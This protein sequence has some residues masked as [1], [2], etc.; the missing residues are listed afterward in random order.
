MKILHVIPSIALVR[1]GPSQAVLAMVKALMYQGINAEIVTTNDNGNNLLDVSLGI[2]T[3]YKCV[4]VRFFARYSPKIHSVREFAFSGQL[5]HWLWHNVTNYDL[6]HVHAIFSYPSTA[7]MFIARLKDIPYICR[8]LGQLCHWSLQQGYQ[9]KRAYLGL[10]EK[11]N[12]NASKALH[13]TTKQE[14]KE[15]DNLNL[16]STSFIL[17]HGISIP[18]PIPEARI[19]LRNKLQVADNET[20]ILFLARL[21]PKKGLDYLISALGKLTHK[22][23]IFVLAGNGDPGYEIEV[24]NLLHQH[25]ISACTHRVGFVQ[26]EYKNLLLQGA[27]IFALTSHSENFGVAVIEALAAGIPALITPG[28]ALASILEQEQIGYVTNLNSD[29]IASSFE[30]CL[31][32]LPELKEKGDRAKK[33]ILENYTW[34]SI[35]LKLV[36]TYQGVINS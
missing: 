9:K 35:A 13:F 16:K 15:A 32:N 6:I 31:N 27:D 36:D 23:F 21:H 7:A 30:Y 18:V 3:E 14:Q 29:A 25:N 24:E 1:G 22:S 34:N 28:V 8:P 33:F 5:T 10:I 20:I 19:K 2:K 26:G 17:P 12:L 11:A 4:P